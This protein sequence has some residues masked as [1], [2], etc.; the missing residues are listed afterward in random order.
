MAEKLLKSDCGN[1]LARSN[2]KSETGYTLM[3]ACGGVLGDTT[4]WINRSTTSRIAFEV[5]FGEIRATFS[6]PRYPSWFRR[7][8]I[9]C[10]HTDCATVA[11]IVAAS[12]G[13]V[14]TCRKPD[15]NCW[16]H[17]G[18]RGTAKISQ[19][20]DAGLAAV[21]SVK[22]ASRKQRGSGMLD[23]ECPFSERWGSASEHHSTGKLE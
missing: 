2:Q 19:S 11:G 1:Y 17:L 21:P 12:G 3:D 5:G 18:Y 15:W 13:V 22:M 16:I 10:F 9:E 7:R 20:V 6:Y 23:I 14:I 4:W 8:W